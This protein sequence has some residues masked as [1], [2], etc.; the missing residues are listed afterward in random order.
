MADLKLAISL[1][2]QQT[3]LRP[4]DLLPLL[5]LA[6]LW[7]VY[8]PDL[9]ASQ[10]TRAKD[11]LGGQ[12]SFDATLALRVSDRLVREVAQWI[13]R[14]DN[15]ACAPLLARALPYWKGHEAREVEALR[16]AVYTT[17]FRKYLAAEDWPLPRQRI[18][19]A[20][21]DTQPKLA[22]AEFNNRSE[23]VSF[24]GYAT[25]QDLIGY[26]PIGMRLDALRRACR[27]IDDLPSRSAREMDQVLE[28]FY[29][30]QKVFSDRSFTVRFFGALLAQIARDSGYD[31]GWNASLMLSYQPQD[32][33][34]KRLII[35]R[36][37]S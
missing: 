31:A 8:S 22:R 18:R 28:F 15:F 1:D 6:A 24:V 12:D 33:E 25:K 23:S 30:Q 16:E 3:G 9:H 13:V 19:N 21:F 35:G 20:L 32:G 29:D 26:Q 11:F 5:D 36:A 17:I 37:E 4:D 14:H 7:R 27:Q 10:L 2:S 34:L